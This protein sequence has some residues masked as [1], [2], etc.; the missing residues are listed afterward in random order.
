MF[1]R[2]LRKSVKAL[3]TIHRYLGI[4]FGLIVLLWCLSGFVMMFVQYPSLSLEERYSYM[5]PLKLER[6][7][8]LPNSFSLDESVFESFSLTQMPSGARLRLNVNGELLYFDAVSG[9]PQSKFSEEMQLVYAQQIANTQNAAPLKPLGKVDVDQW[10][11]IP[12]VA[13]NAP[14]SVYE[15]N[16]DKKSRLYFSQ[17]NGELVQHVTFNERTWGWI[18][19]VVHWIYPTTIRANTELWVQLV[20]WLS[21]VSLFMVVV[22]AILG[23]LRLRH[24]GRWRKSPYRGRFWW[25]HYS[26][27]IAGLLMLTW[28]FSGLMSMYPWGLMESRSFDQEKQ[29]LRGTNFSVFAPFKKFL[30][31]INSAEIPESTVELKGILV[32]GFLNVTAVDRKGMSTLIE[33]IPLTPSRSDAFPSASV[34]A[35]EMRPEVA[36]SSVDLITRGDSYYYNH[37]SKRSFP[38][39]RIVYE[40]GERVY[41]DGK[42]SEFIAAFDGGRKTAR[43]LYLGL[44]R[45][46]FFPALNAGLAW[47]LS[48]GSLLLITTVSVGIGCWLAL[49]C[50]QRLLFPK[51]KSSIRQL[52]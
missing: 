27:L 34:L 43:W 40:D 29:N 42:T 10:S 4:V 12:S 31:Q 45:G 1:D 30:T 28:L 20:I 33:R 32:A 44:H 22:G 14:F 18:G 38:V 35:A 7:C 52:A 49:R 50:W 48:W 23:V 17:T 8:K 9:V 36:I 5:A 3:V 46:D 26:S 47:I 25:H 6:C 19:S 37:H 13:K 16:D 21:V 39:Y 51:R 24:R 41:L 15:L 11:I 2:L